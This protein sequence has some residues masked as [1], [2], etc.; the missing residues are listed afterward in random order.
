MFLA[1]SEPPSRSRAQN[2][3]Y[4][5]SLATIAPF[6]SHV[7][8]YTDTATPTPPLHPINS[9][10]T[11]GQS[12]QK[13]VSQEAFKTS[14]TFPQHKPTFTKEVAPPRTT[15][16]EISHSY[17]TPKPRHTTYSNTANRRGGIKIVLPPQFF[18]FAPLIKIL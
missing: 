5:G 10:L 12:T 1:G 7:N 2:P 6:R 3:I 15:S 4:H 14:S 11:H 17:H 13:S 16:T 9:Q 18:Y 8:C